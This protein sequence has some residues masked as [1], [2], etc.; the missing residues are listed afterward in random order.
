MT[1]L[2]I[3]DSKFVSFCIVEQTRNNYL[4][5]IEYLFKLTNYHVETSFKPMEITP[6]ILNTY[7]QYFV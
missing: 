1:V 6:Y 2:Y 4:L 5:N 3:T 7:I